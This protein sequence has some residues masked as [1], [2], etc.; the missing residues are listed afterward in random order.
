MNTFVCDADLRLTYLSPAAARTMQALRDEVM[1]EF[2]VDVDN[3]LG[4]SIHSFHKDPVAVERILAHPERFPHCATFPL[5][6][7]QLQTTIDAIRDRSD[8]VTGFVAVVDNITDKRELSEHVARAAAD[9][10]ESS[11]RL[12]R[13]ADDLDAMTVEVTREAAAMTVG[14]DQLMTSIQTVSRSAAEATTSTRAVVAAATEATRSFAELNES[15]A[16]ISEVTDLISSIAEQTKLLA[17]NASIE[18]TRAGAA[19]TGFAVVASEV[20]QLAQRTGNA[21]GRINEMITAIQ[22]DSA[23]ARQA[24]EA[25]AADIERVDAEQAQIAE[26]VEQEA[27]SAREIAVVVGEVAASVDVVTAATTAAREAAVSLSGKSAYLD[28]IV[29][30]LVV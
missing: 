20:K 8:R 28:E 29:P 9:L 12:R 25:I 14:T 18:A 2:G 15:S 27:C 26:A 22:A 24:I 17:L 1:A 4:L 3:L 21:T 16:R 7:L 5:G 23:A 11:T 19:G 10:D 13:V 6:S 30:T